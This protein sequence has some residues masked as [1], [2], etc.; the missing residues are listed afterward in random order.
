MDVR[1]Y[2]HSKGW[3]F[4]EVYRNGAPNGILNCPFCGDMEKKFAINLETGAWNCLRLNNCGRRGSF[5]QLQKDMGD[6]PLPVDGAGMVYKPANKQMS[7]QKVYKKP[8]LPTQCLDGAAI[9]WI[10][11]ERGLTLETIQRFDVRLSE[12]GKEL[13]WICYKDGKPVNV[14][15]R[16][17]AAK[18]FRNAKDAEPVL[19][20]RDRCA[21][22]RDCL[23][24]TEGEFDCMALYQCGVDAVSVPN[25]TGDTRW[26]DNEWDY[27]QGFAEIVLCFDNDD[28]GRKATAQLV[29]RF[30]RWR[31]RIAVLPEKDAN[32]C[33]LYGVPPETVKSAIDNAA[34]QPPELL[35][36]AIEFMGEVMEL[37]NHPNLV[38]GTPTAFGPLD[39]ILRG[40]RDQELTVWSGK[41]GSGKS[42]VLNQT[43]LDLLKQ[44]VP[45]CM[46]SLEL[47]PRQY[48]RWAVM[49]WLEQSRPP[50]DDVYRAFTEFGVFLYIIN[51]HEEITPD[52]LLDC[53]DYAARRYGVKHF[54]VDSLT[55]ISFPLKDENNEHKKF[56]SDFLSFVK[57]HNAHGHLVAHPRKGFNDD[58]RPG[59]DDIKGTGDI[60]NLA[61]NV[62]MMWR[63]SEDLKQKA[64]S[65]G[66][67]M[68]D[69]KLIVKKNREW[70]TEG[71]VDLS[72]FASVKKF[73]AWT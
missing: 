70:G 31:T 55:R 24:I 10:E 71:T 15:Y 2:L 33:I 68:P 19:Y 41:S 26:I 20:N 47:P 29:Q 13:A 66:R 34:F 44:G 46:A 37:F 17:M 28:A 72:F 50:D 4:K 9:K 51:T 7:V 65:Q 52:R 5:W 16:K 58:D 39:D 21:E 45:V 1:A 64:Q 14:K 3:Q 49:Q 48:L 53:F 43:V 42:T 11:R 40:W 69:A 54:V 22:N 30:G 8:E 62:L 57:M 73:R 6:N 67:E 12:N 63:P 60:T 38:K 18:E 23:V 32:D 59:K 56:V 61:H 35:V 27:L 25:G 36:G